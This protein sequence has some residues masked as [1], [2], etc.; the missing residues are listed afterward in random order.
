M[1]LL[2]AGCQ[3]IKVD[4][5]PIPEPVACT[6]EAMLCPDGS[7]VGRAGPNCEFATCPGTP[8][9]SSGIRGYIHMGPTCPVQRDP[10]D[11]NCEDKPYATVSIV[12]SNTVGKQYKGQTDMIGNF[13]LDVP[14]GAYIVKIMPLNIFP[15]C[16]EKEAVVTK[17]KFT[18]IDISCDT[19]IR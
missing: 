11:P 16:E 8:T 2:A 7:Y 6:Q 14:P 1:P 3:Q 13:S 12:A 4:P 19:G 17:N 10:P 15:R 9:S 18:S 5:I